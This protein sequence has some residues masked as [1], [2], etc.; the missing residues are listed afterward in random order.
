MNT[1]VVDSFPLS[2][3]WFNTLRPRQN[4][5]HFADDTFK[6]IFLNDNVKILI[7]ISLKFVRYGRIYNIPGLVQIMAWRSTGDKLLSEPMMVNL[8]T[9][10]CVTRPQWVKEKITDWNHSIPHT[11]P[12]VLLFRPFFFVLEELIQYYLKE[13]MHLGINS[14]LNFPSSFVVIS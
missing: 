10:I 7:R 1:N 13:Q 9:H 4:G 8:P 14:M 3:L 11:S 6:R 2:V 5:C 12:Y